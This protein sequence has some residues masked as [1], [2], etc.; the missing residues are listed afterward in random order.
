MTAN[1]EELD[2]LL[3]SLE[4]DRT[5]VAYALR[6]AAEGLRGRGRLTVAAALEGVREFRA[7]F[8]ALR[9]RLPPPTRETEPRRPTAGTSAEASGND[10]SLPELRRRLEELWRRER[11]RQTIAVLRQLHAATPAAVPAVEHI[12]SR[13]AEW[14]LQ[15][16]PS[17]PA[18]EECD[19]I[20]RR[21]DENPALALV[22]L[23]RHR[24]ALSDPEWDACVTLVRGTFGD[25][26]ATAVIRG[27]LILTP[28]SPPATAVA[29]SWPCGSEGRRDAGGVES[30]SSCSRPGDGAVQ[31]FDREC[32]PST[33]E[34]QVQR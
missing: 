30:S 8:D 11:T 19:L 26:V 34:F 12:R 15:L 32:V 3:Q 16:D 18:A 28:E 17:V 10:E 21:D 25:G 5:V 4:D 20:H 24:D 23:V 9:R 27:R 13:A 14:E 1:F 7:R 33:A 31:D 6:R 2:S 22:Q 29:G